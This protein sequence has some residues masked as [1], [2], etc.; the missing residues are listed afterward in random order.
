MMTGYFENGMR[1][2]RN[3]TFGV[4]LALFSTL[5]AQAETNMESYQYGG[6]DRDWSAR[7]LIDTEIYGRDGQRLGE[8]NDMIVDR[9]GRVAAV[10]LEVGDLNDLGA[11]DGMT[12]IRIPWD[13][14]EL[15]PKLR[16]I[17]VVMNVETLPDDSL[18]LPNAVP[19]AEDE[20]R[21]RNAL[22][23]TLLTRERA[24]YGEVSDLIISG[25]GQMEAVLIQPME[26]LTH[27]EIVAY[28]YQ[29]FMEAWT[30]EDIAHRLPHSLE[31][32]GKLP[33]FNRDR[34][35]NS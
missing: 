22:G 24:A 13:Q 17:N 29:S 12:H 20:W 35:L 27:P 5:P 32:L 26:N 15:D 30:P 9:S 28:P 2:L 14:V 4:A 19:V 16:G 7:L 33:R 34:L 18:F 8:V 25:T 1:W 3:A 11:D 31:E 23:D 6:L 10:V 21:A